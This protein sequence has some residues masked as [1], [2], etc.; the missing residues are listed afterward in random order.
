[1][2]GVEDHIADNA[3]FVTVDSKVSLMSPNVGGT[4]QWMSPELSDLDQ[5]GVLDGQQ[6]EQSNCYTLGM[7]V[8]GYS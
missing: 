7:V 5:F 4:I 8:Y 1:M 3:S 6:T 2:D